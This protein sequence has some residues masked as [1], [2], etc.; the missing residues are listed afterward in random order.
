MNSRI[1][2]KKEWA[3]LLYIRESTLTQKEIAEKVGVTQKTLNLWINKENWPKLRQSFIVTKEEQLRRIYMQIDELNTC[4]YQR[5]EGRRFAVKGEAD[6]LVK[7]TSAA[8]VLETEA[9]IADIIEVSKRFLSW[10]KNFDF[11]KA[12]EFSALL[13]GFI[14]DQIK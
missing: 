4:I 13:D 5:E 3:R 8:R 6:T 7:L 1:S 2:E 14:R 9:S 10:L 12:K 11:E